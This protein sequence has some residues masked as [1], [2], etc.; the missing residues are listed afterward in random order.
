[1]LL[2][3]GSKSKH[4]LEELIDKSADII[5]LSILQKYGT[6]GM[7]PRSHRRYIVYGL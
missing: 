1:M 7:G 4:D 6:T 3:L 5:N 2:N